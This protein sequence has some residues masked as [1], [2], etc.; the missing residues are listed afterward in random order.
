[1]KNC[2]FCSIANDLEQKIILSNEHC[3]FL[4]K[5]QEILIGSGVIVPKKHR[6]TLFDLS[7]D[8]WTATFELLQEVK[9][10]IDNKCKPTGYNIGWNVGSVGG[11][12]IFHAHLHVIPRYED[13][14]FAGKGIRYWLKQSQNKRDT[15]ITLN[16]ED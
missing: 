14:P 8:E 6:E 10:Y 12:E 15:A 13:E 1:M 5:P 16:C 4:Q 11:Q 7:E 2:L 3:M 9:V